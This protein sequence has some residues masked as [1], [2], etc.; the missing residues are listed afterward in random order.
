MMAKVLKASTSDY[1]QDVTTTM[2]P[3]VLE[4]L[5]TNSGLSLVDIEHGEYPFYLSTNV[6]APCSAFDLVSLPIKD[7]LGSL[8]S[9]GE[10]PYAFEDARA[11]FDEMVAAGMIRKDHKGYAIDDNRY[12]IVVARRKF[13]DH[14]TA[15]K[16]FMRKSA[17]VS[18]AKAADLMTSPTQVSLDVVSSF[19]ELL[20]ASLSG[21]RYSPMSSFESAVKHTIESEGHD[22][23]TLNI[24]DLGSRPAR[25]SPTQLLK[26]AFPDAKLHSANF[27]GSLKLADDMKT[28]TQQPLDI[29]FADTKTFPESRLSD[30]PDASVDIVMSAFGL[31]YFEDPNSVIRQVHRLLKPGGSFITTTW[32]RISLE[33]ISNCIMTKVI[34]QGHAP[35]EFLSFSRFSAPHELEKL[36]HYGGLGIVKSEHHEF[37]FVLAK[38]GIMNDKAFHA[39]ILPVRH[40]LS[41]LEESGTHPNAFADAR[42][43]F[44]DMV[45]NGELVS[46][47]THGCLITGPNRFN[48]VIARRLFEDSDGLTME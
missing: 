15:K 27:T 37:P 3:H 17:S 47:D 25:G 29:G 46:I 14:D 6:E 12:K 34:G 28:G 32:D 24:L 39:A 11:A 31:H 36:I 10:R 30:I 41:D 8:M 42:K 35:Y 1:V 21:N 23:K 19:D 44:D 33:A 20:S 26:D 5:I 45:E 40:I 43:A 4:K 38:D 13:E 9:S 18:S 48:L 22:I 7:K 2:K 16:V